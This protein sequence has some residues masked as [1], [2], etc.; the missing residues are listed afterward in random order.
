ML[1]IAQQPDFCQ[2]LLAATSNRR[3]THVDQ[4]LQ[5]LKF[6]SRDTVDSE[7]HQLLRQSFQLR[8]MRWLYSKELPTRLRGSYLPEDIYNEQQKDPA[9]RGKLLLRAM[10]D[11]DLLPV[12]NSFTL[13]VSCPFFVRFSG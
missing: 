3:V 12:D 9:L 1:D 10:A 2:M 11:T 7:L 8:L 13:N 5:K 4:I 6:D